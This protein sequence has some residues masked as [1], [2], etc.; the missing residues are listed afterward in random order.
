[1]SLNKE[2]GAIPQNEKTFQIERFC[3]RRRIR[4]FDR[5]LRRQVLYPA[6]LCDRGLKCVGVAGFEPATSWSQTRRDDRAT[7]HPEKIVNAESK[8]FEPLVQFPIRMFSKHVLSATQATLQMLMNV[9]LL[10]G[11]KC[12]VSG[13]ILQQNNLF[14]YVFFYNSPKA[15]H[16]QE[17]SKPLRP[18]ST[19]LAPNGSNRI[20]WNSVQYITN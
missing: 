5:L 20:S 17:Y 10:S 2:G 8:G 3:D 11:C 9:M 6:E 13:Y 15:T 14:F 16:Y 4:T 19:T 7:L 1:M 18:I 12:K